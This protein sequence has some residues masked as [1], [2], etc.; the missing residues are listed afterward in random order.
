MEKS[1]TGPA[2]VARYPM[3]VTAMAREVQGPRCNGDRAGCRE[4]E[5]GNLYLAK[6]EGRN[7]ECEALNN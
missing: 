3:K 6:E 7:R 1:N 2:A 4:E 5:G